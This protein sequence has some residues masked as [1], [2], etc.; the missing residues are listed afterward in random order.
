VAFFTKRT[1]DEI[2]KKAD[3]EDMDELKTDFRAFMQAQEQRHQQNSSRLDTIIST[4]GR[5]NP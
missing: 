4:L 1:I 3:K 5:R 2:D